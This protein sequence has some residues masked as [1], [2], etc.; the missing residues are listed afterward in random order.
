VLRNR[1]AD[2]RIAIELIKLHEVSRVSDALTFDL[3]SN[4][5]FSSSVFQPS[6]FVFPFLCRPSSESKNE[7]A[8]TGESGDEVH[9]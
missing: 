3:A 9:R 1:Q 2:T 5:N 4:P 6:V 8:K 7:T